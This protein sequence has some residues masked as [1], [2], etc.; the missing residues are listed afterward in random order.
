MPLWD[1]PDCI[2]FPLST[3]IEKGATTLTIFF[4]VHISLS[5]CSKHTQSYKKNVHPC[6]KNIGEDNQSRL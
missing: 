5:G 6:K 4:E 1:R 3:K 2:T